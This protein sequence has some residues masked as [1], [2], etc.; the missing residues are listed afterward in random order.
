MPEI[1]FKIKCCLLARETF[2]I[3]LGVT[4]QSCVP[5]RRRV[6]ARSRPPRL[7][8]PTPNLRHRN[9]GK[10]A[11]NGRAKRPPSRR[12]RGTPP[13]EVPG[14]GE[15]H[16]PRV[17]RRPLRGGRVPPLL[18]RRHVSFFPFILSFRQTAKPDT[19]L[20]FTAAT[21]PRSATTTA[22]ST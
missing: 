1:P 18:Q 15:P 6:I 5:F 3:G 20:F 17:R 8:R 13:Q 9:G 16:L 7:Q 11:G 4:H 21:R 2:F 14:H 19:T 10:T 22:R 12:G